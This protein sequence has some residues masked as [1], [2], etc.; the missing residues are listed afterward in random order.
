M[1]K[2][3]VLKSHQ[4][5]MKYF[6]NTS[7]LFGEK[8][9]RIVVGLFVVIWVARYLGPEQFGLFSYAQSFAG[10]FTAI[11]T[12]GLDGIV[13]RELVK[14]E[15]RRDELIG[16]AFW[17]KILGALG[18]LIV[19]AIAVNFTSNDSYTNSLVFVIASATIFQSFNV[20]DM[21]FQSKVLSKYIVYANVISLF[22]S[23]IVKITL[24]LNEAPLIAFAWVILFDSF[25]L[26][27]GF[28]YFYLKNRR[29]NEQP[30]RYSVFDTESSF[31]WKFNKSTA[32]SLLKD[33]WPLIL[34]GIVIS[35]YM[36]IDQVMIKEMM[37]AEAV[38][39][40]AAAV[41]LSEAWY[42]IPM[43]IASSLFPAI[44]NAKKQSEELY[45]ARLQKL[46]S[47]M[48]WLAIAIAL[49]MTF[50]SDW[51][52]H[53][54]YG[55]QYNQAGS[56]LMIH[57]WAGVF[58]FLG[59]ASGKWLLSENLQIFSTVNTSIGAIV[60][61][62]L[63][64]ILIPKIGVSGAAW[65]TLISYFVAAYLCLLFFKKTRINFANL[66]KSLFFIRIFNVQK[67]S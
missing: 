66:S 31:A 37:N 12:L 7:W 18:V 41:R 64:Y 3:K 32:F 26:A 62:W 28:I 49:P 1:Q 59:V 11:A 42:F 17:L 53:F 38:G 33:S 29:H 10:I 25:I 54:L 36:K 4:G 61:I 9:L 63:N 20:V 22:I 16:T 65:A 14:D 60:N 8:I 67:N 34:S 40:Y 50:L 48:V 58:V 39:Q 55:E 5:F 19:L 45:Y 52:V 44:I 30:N 56:V 27:S 47:L 35:I 21:Y 2:L 43:V 57:I 15:S 24:I 23:S 51:V 6:I 46:Y 13:I